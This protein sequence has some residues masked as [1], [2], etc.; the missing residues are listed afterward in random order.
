[1]SN[2]EKGFLYLPTFTFGCAGPPSVKLWGN[3]NSTQHYVQNVNVTLRCNMENP[4]FAL[5]CRSIRREYLAR[6]AFLITALD[7][8][9]S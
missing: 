6:S 7:S 1:M 8:V 2:Y 3:G 5:R 9:M 4:S